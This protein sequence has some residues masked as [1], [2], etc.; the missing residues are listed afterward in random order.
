[1]QH[2]TVDGCTVPFRMLNRINKSV[3]IDVRCK[4]SLE[5]GRHDRLTDAEKRINALASFLVMTARCTLNGNESVS[6]DI[7]EADVTSVDVP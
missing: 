5:L 3:T 6:S 7:L 4:S 2:C 1:M